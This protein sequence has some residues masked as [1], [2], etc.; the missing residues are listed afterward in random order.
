MANRIFELFAAQTV[1]G[2][3]GPFALDSD[4]F[5]VYVSGL[6]DGGTVRMYSSPDKVNWFPIVGGWFSETKKGQPVEYAEPFN[7]NVLFLKAVL[8]DAGVAADVTV[9]VL[10]THR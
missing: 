8:A 6:L 10:T 4:L 3:S 7:E 1:D 5:T 2:D 9:T